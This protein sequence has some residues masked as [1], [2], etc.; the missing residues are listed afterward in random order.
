MEAA[1]LQIHQEMIDLLASRPALEQIVDFKI[2]DPAQRRLEEL[3]DKNREAELTPEERA[4]MDKYLQ[5]RHVMI[6][7][8]ASARRVVNARPEE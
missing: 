2:S 8:K 1:R 7:L 4:E 5:Y 6:L 3:L